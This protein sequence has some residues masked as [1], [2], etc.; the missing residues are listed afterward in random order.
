MQLLIAAVI[1]LASGLASGLFGVGGGMVMVPAMVYFMTMDIKLAVGT[2]L[3]VIIPTAASGVFKHHQLGNVN[4]AI[5]LTLIPT[6]VCGSYLGAW[7]TTYIP[8]TNLKRGFGAFLI[9]AG[10]KL[11]TGR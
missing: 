7:A 6:A 4:W 10:L 9:L 8:S 5:V 1:G 3:A 11:V 2:S